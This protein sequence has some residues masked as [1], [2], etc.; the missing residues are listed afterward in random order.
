[1]SGYSS[2]DKVGRPDLLQGEL[3]SGTLGAVQSCRDEAEDKDGGPARQRQEVGTQ[4][5]TLRPCVRHLEAATSGISVYG[6]S[7][8]KDSGFQRV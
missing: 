6:Q 4:G 1:M 8:Y 5:H 2:A 7:P 3:E